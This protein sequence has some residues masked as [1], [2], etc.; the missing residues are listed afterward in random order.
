MMY[1]KFLGFQLKSIVKH[2]FNFS[3]NREGCTVHNVRH[4]I[5]LRIKQWRKLSKFNTFRATH[6]TALLIRYMYKG[7]RCEFVMSFFN[8]REEKFKP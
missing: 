6:R 3:V 7:Y 2:N 1:A 8:W 5:S 4:E